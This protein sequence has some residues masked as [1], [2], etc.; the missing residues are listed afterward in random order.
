MKIVLFLLDKVVYYKLPSI[1]SGSYSFDPYGDEEKL[2]NIDSINGN[3][4]LH[5]TAFCSIIENQKVVE[6]SILMPNNFYVLYKDKKTYL[7]FVNNLEIP[8]ILKFSY[9]EKI[10]L[11][12][13]KDDNCNI[14]YDCEYLKDSV[15]KIS[16]KNNQLLLQKNDDQ[17]IYINNLAL[18]N[19]FYNINFGDEIRIFG[20]NLK[21]LKELVLIE[22]IN[23]L[24]IKPNEN[25]KVFIYNDNN[26]LKDIEIKDVDLY[27]KEDYFYKSPRF[28]RD[29]KTKEIKLTPP[30]N[31][32]ENEELPLILVVGPMLTMGIT[33]GVTV[34]NTIIRI[35]SG[36][37]NLQKSWPSIVISVVMVIS[38]VMWPLITQIY[39]KKLKSRKRKKAIN[40]YTEYLNQK[41]VE[42]DSEKNFQKAILMENLLTI[43]ECINFI[44]HRNILFWDKRVDQ[45][46]FLN[47]RIGFGNEKL[48]VLIDYSEEDFS[49]ENSEIKEKADSLKKEY[50]Y[51]E[52]VPI[53][54]SFFDNHITAIMGNDK[55]Y[56]FTNNILIQLFAY[57]SYDDVKLVVFTNEENSINWDYIKYTNYNFNNMKNFRFFASNPKS[58]KRVSEYLEFELKT[59]IS[60][61]E[62]KKSTIKKPYYVIFVDD[63][64]SVK[65]TEFMSTLVEM[66]EN[67]GFS[68]II[69]E[70]KI[71]SLPS[72]CNNFIMLDEAVSGVLKHSY[73]NQEYFKFKDEI[74]YGIDMNSIAKIIS[75]IPIEFEDN[76]S[77]ELPEMYTFL[78]MQQV[79]KVEQL[80]ILNRWNTNDSISSLK[81]EV[82]IDERGNIIFLDLHEKSHGPHGLIAGTTGSGKS[83]F[84]ITY[85]LSM[86]IN[87]SPDDISFILIDYKGG[88]LAGAFE[89]KI[90]NIVLPHLAGTI[91]N[92][93]KSEMDRTLISINSELKRRQEIFNDARNKLRE[94]TI[95]IYKYQSFYKEGKLSEP[96]PHLF[97]IC[98]EFAE[99]KS[100]QPD[101]MDSLISAAR[102]GRSLGVHLIL[103]T[104]KPSGVVNDQIWSNTKF[105]ICL[106]VQSEADSKEVLKRTDAAFLRQSGRFYLQVGEDEIF[107][108]GQSGWCGAKYYPSDKVLK[109]I[110]KNINIIDES[111]TFL[112]TIQSDSNEKK[113]AHSDQITSILNE[114]I[115]IA[116]IE[117]KSARKLWL[118]NIPSII[119]VD[120][121]EKKYNFNKSEYGVSIVIGE[122]D[123]PEMQ[124][125]DVLLFDYLK[126]GNTII[127]G[128]DIIEREMLINEIIYASSKNYTS[129][130]INFY[131][132]DYGSQ[133]MG[134]YSKLPQMGGIV[135]PDDS[136][137]Y[138]KLFKYLGDEFQRRK[139]LLIESGGD[140]LN[141]LKQGGQ[142]LPIIA[143]ILNNYSSILE[144]NNN[145]YDELPKLLRDSERYGIVFILSTNSSNGIPTKITQNFQNIYVL[146]LKDSNEMDFIF[147][148][149]LKK[150]PKEIMGRGFFNNGE[151]LEFQVASICDEN[152]YSNFINSFIDEQER[153]NR[154]RA[155]PIPQLPEHVS[156][157]CIKQFINT[158][159]NVPIGIDNYELSLCTFNFKSSVGNVITSSKLLNTKNFV[160]SLISVLRTISNNFLLIFDSKK[161]LGLSQNNNYITED[162]ENKFIQLTDYI[163]KCIK[164]NSNIEGTIL[165]YGFS[166]VVSLIYNKKLLEDL[167]NLI[168]KYEKINVIIVDEASKIKDFSYEFWFKNLFS[169]DNCIW[170]GKGLGDQS[171]LRLSNYSKEI[172]LNYN[173]DMG[174]YIS[175]GECTL[176]KL[177]DFISKDDNQLK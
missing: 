63:Y 2:I 10:N 122:Y 1:V 112:K 79:G 170:V 109:Q 3:W 172:S 120:D 87:Y 146:R 65:D 117:N 61:M 38:T 31:V 94:S 51:I 118:D 156:Y 59:R 54:Y 129:E 139:K 148:K 53:G 70:K 29:I 40:K 27:Q 162:I 86:C 32:S 176:I 126:N 100:Q 104:Q 135:F 132:V 168:K 16:V 152:T 110:D 41:K 45:S 136:E 97:I 153:I 125:Q 67:I 177:L 13:G 160:L 14:K 83:E 138:K 91:T 151:I 7:L 123:A 46:D 43:N 5:S 36:E 106:K 49:L 34:L 147:N 141:Y 25:F 166:N 68:L 157:D 175:D 105:R 163:E 64:A 119:L 115:K 84:I 22:K 72:K 159:E 149:H 50:E 73:E 108:L 15:V 124:K 95:D 56:D 6:E 62:E 28:K 169:F 88:G 12:I 52:N 140:Y 19:N 127:Y 58:I 35:D 143:V 21:I 161:E 76:E 174:F 165:I 39:N 121:I 92:L 154:T 81:T 101:F 164:N 74:V 103:A 75:N 37:T 20:L 99:L 66:D 134:K 33:S 128:S 171:L 55:I 131:I 89:N 77:M 114:I 173:N 111:C 71:N 17:I 48:D 82:G 85:I 57:Y 167:F 133:T 96:V 4:I 18:K 137:K 145:L 24:I 30:P 150:V 80:N 144:S 42:L 116:N 11:I 26:K 47:F 60:Q 8:N 78:E 102:I 158:L 44:Y 155:N 113:I 93:D 130:N 107:V 9:N 98:D 90:N 23:D 142:N 69:L